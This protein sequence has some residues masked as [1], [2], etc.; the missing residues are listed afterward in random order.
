MARFS[1]TLK[2]VRISTHMVVYLL[3][4][5]TA[6]TIFFIQFGWQRKGQTADHMRNVKKILE[7]HQMQTGG[8]PESLAA[9]ERAGLMI[10]PSEQKDGWGREIRYEATNRHG[11][12]DSGVPLYDECEIRSAGPNGKFGD[13]DD[14]TWKGKGNAGP[15]PGPPPLPGPGER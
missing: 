9:L 14:V 2:N 11:R 4:V 8:Y 13:D 12:S 6:L 3:L 7:I 1:R 15:A 10:P 5:G